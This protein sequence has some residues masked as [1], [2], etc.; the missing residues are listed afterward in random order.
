[1]R[2]RRQ[3]LLAAAVLVALLA[4]YVVGTLHL[5]HSHDG[6]W[7]KESCAMC[8][9]QNPAVAGRQWQRVVTVRVAERT[10]LQNSPVRNPSPARVPLPP[11]SPPTA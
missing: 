2:T 7:S 1:M 11:R 6:P 4:T 3:E 10:A 5:G 9:A 8:G